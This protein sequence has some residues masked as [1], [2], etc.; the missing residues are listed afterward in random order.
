MLNLIGP[1]TR[2]LWALVAPLGVTSTTGAPINGRYHNTLGANGAPQ[3]P[4]APTCLG[5]DNHRL[6]H[7]TVLVIGAFMHQDPYRGTPGYLNSTRRPQR[8]R[9]TLDARMGA[10]KT[11]ANNL[12]ARHKHAPGFATRTRAKRT[13]HIVRSIWQDRLWA[14]QNQL[15][16]RYHLTNDYPGKPGRLMFKGSSTFLGLSEPCRVYQRNPMD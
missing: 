6:V 16:T 4:L 15:R 7:D 5:T 3:A 11:H 8:H 12:E 14:T 1:R 13:N 2:Q 10:P 9:C